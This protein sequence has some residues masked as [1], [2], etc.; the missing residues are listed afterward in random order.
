MLRNNFRTK[1]LAILAVPMAALIGITAFAGYDR[2]SESQR[3]QQAATPDR[4][5][6]R[7]RGSC[8]RR[9]SSSR[10]S[11]ADVVANPAGPRDQLTA[12]RAATDAAV[13]GYDHAVQQAGDVG[14]PAFNDG[15]DRVR[16]NLNALD[17][18]VSRL[19]RSR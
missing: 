14:S 3:R 17:H 4:R 15:T 1:L 9:R 5:R 16:R 11:S 10:R 18:V 8:A 13:A 2:L 7:R 6:R 12:Q 19:G